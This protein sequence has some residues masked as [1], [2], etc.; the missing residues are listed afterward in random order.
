VGI[1][2][3]VNQVAEGGEVGDH[4]GEGDLAAVDIAAEAQRVLDRAVDQRAG[5]ADRP[6]R[7]FAEEAVNQRNV[8]FGTVGT[9]LQTGRDESG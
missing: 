9:D 4:A 5:N 6:C 3:H 7:L 8:E 1:T 2:K